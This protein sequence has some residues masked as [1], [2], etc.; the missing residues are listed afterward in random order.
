M[1]LALPQQVIIDH[2][3]TR[4]VWPRGQ[5]AGRRHERRTLSTYPAAPF[6]PHRTSTSSSGQKRPGRIGRRV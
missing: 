2:D 4:Q 1:G 5:C 6:T 3:D